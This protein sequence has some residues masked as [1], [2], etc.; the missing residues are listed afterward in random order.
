MAGR[1]ALSGALFV[2][3]QAASQ[4]GIP[5]LADGSNI[6]IFEYMNPSSVPSGD[7]C[8]VN[9]YRICG[10]GLGRSDVMT[11]G[12]CRAACFAHSIETTR[13]ASGWTPA[14]QQ[15]K[16]MQK[17]MAEYCERGVCKGSLL[18]ADVHKHEHQEGDAWGYPAKSSGWP[19]RQCAKQAYYCQEM[20]QNMYH[21]PTGDLGDHPG[22]DDNW[23]ANQASCKSDCSKNFAGLTEYWDEHCSCV[24]S[25]GKPSL[26]PG[27][28]QEKHEHEEHQSVD[29][30]SFMQ[31][32][33]ELK[34]EL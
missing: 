20:C 29:V 2:V 24:K 16:Y 26:P 13:A 6:N 27:L 32:T 14:R 25:K 33:V 34:T 3:C 28:L 1:V 12:S 7:K 9:C 10:D 5:G 18:Q 17:V 30:G 22:A 23:R 8:G 21:K 11:G 15:G 19:K 4:R 31:T